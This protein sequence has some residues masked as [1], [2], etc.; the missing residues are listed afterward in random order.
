MIDRDADQQSGKRSDRAWSP[1][2]IAATEPGGKRQSDAFH[3]VG[4]SGSRFSSESSSSVLPF[5]G[6][7]YFSDAQLPKS[8]NRHRSLQNGMLGSLA[9]TALPQM[10]QPHVTG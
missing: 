1:G 6:I 10:G 3:R 2:E 9:L 5:P 8:T 7:E 4:P